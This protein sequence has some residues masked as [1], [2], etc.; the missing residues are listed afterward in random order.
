MPSVTQSSRHRQNRSFRCTALVLLPGQEARRASSPAAPL[1]HFTRLRAASAVQFEQS[2]R[3]KYCGRS[4]PFSP[5]DYREGPKAVASQI[6]ASP[7]IMQERTCRSPP[8]DQAG[9]RDQRWAVRVMKPDA[10]G[11]CSPSG[12]P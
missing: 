12:I 8:P 4:V 9:T 2:K 11:I 3:K 7:S 10:D 1:A 6:T 5:R